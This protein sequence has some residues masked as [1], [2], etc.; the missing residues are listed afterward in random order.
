[1]ANEAMLTGES[2]PQIKESLA[3]VDRELIDNLKSGESLHDLYNVIR[4]FFNF[5]LFLLLLLPLKLHTYFF[6]SS[7]FLTLFFLLGLI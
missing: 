6:S 2:V 1:M 5:F 3:L 7:I 4:H